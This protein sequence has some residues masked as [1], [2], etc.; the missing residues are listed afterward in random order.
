LS[1]SHWCEVLGQDLL[2]RLRIRP[3]ASP[4][5]MELPHAGRLRVRVS[6]APV[7]GAANERLMQLL[8]REL[9]VPRAAL[10]LVRGVRS[11]DKDVL[12]RNAARRERAL[13]RRFAA[14]VEETRS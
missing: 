3:R 13:T 10:I 9:E 4:E 2:L 5:G 7:D 12:V 1:D 11:R 6:A 8:S 14:R